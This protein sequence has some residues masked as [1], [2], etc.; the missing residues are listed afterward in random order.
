MKPITEFIKE[1]DIIIYDVYITTRNN[2]S[3]TLEI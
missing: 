3:V 1:N 2:T